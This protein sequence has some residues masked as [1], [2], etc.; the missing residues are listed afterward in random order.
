MEMV[1]AN[2]DSFNVWMLGKTYEKVKD[3][4]I[5]PTIDTLACSRRLFDV[6]G[7]RYPYPNHLMNDFMTPGA[8]PYR[9]VES[10]RFCGGEFLNAFEDLSQDAPF[11]V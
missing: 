2:E 11:I 4:L 3:T 10:A 6:L 1:A 9:A 7:R 5:N 8:E